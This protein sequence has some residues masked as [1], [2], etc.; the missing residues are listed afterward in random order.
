MIWNINLAAQRGIVRLV[1][2]S[3]KKAPNENQVR[4]SS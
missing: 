3:E 4:K 2:F 1:N